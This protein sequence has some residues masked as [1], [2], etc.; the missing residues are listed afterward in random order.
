[1]SLRVSVERIALCGPGLT[2]WPRA[3]TVLRGEAAYEAAAIVVPPPARLPAA[4]RRR[5]GPSVKLALAGAENLCAGDPAGGAATARV[6]RSSG[7]DSENCHV[8]CEALAADEPQISPTRFTNSVH[9]APSGYWSIAAGAR[10]PSSS[11]C[12]HDASFAGGLLEAALQA[13]VDARPVALI[14]YDVPYPFPL[15]DKRPIAAA[16][17]SAWLLTPTADARRKTGRESA[18]VHVD[19]NV[20]AELSFDGWTAGEPEPLADPALERLRAGVPAARCL[21]LMTAI[22]RGGESVVKLSGPPGQVLAVQVRAV[23]VRVA[24]R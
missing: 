2:D 21:P 8:L 19:G 7:G 10:V 12:V 17:G 18:G 13:V 16:F 4:E 23:Q 22:A 9:N 24:R 6:F 14:A 1:M 3:A 5:V 20:S 15:S 11:L